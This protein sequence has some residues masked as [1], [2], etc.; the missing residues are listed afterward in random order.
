MRV[1]IRKE[2]NDLYSVS[3][4]RRHRHETDVPE[5]RHIPRAEVKA[6]VAEMVKQSVPVGYLDH[7]EPT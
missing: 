3:V 5:V 7:L 6:A 1:T 4:K 2:G